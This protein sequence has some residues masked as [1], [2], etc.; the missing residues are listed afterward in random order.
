[1][2]GRLLLLAVPVPMVY[3]SIPAT[4]ATMFFWSLMP[5]LLVLLVVLSMGW[6]LVWYDDRSGGSHGLLIQW[7]RCFTFTHRYDPHVRLS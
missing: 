1:M 4:A 7:H 5:A 6:L 3:A 2:H